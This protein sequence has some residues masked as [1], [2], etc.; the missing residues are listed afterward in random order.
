MVRTRR[1]RPELTDSWA[2]VDEDD[3]DN[4]SST[5]QS[6]SQIYDEAD[7]RREMA[8]EY[9]SRIFQ[10]ERKSSRLNGSTSNLDN[11]DNARRRSLRSSVEPPEL[12]MPAS[13][14]G[15][16]SSRSSAASAVLQNARAAKQRASTPHFRMNERSMTSDAGSM[17]KIPERTSAPRFRMSDR[18]MTSDAGRIHGGASRLKEE[19]V[20]DETYG[21]QR[22]DKGNDAVAAGVG[23][24]WQRVL[25]PLLSYTTSVV[26]L[27]VENAKPILGW[28]L[29][30][31]VLVAAFVFA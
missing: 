3:Y 23:M 17:R 7:E 31:Y 13:P 21:E 6:N 9:R 30:L 19:I 5:T 8:D 27:A 4:T 25:R 1:A 20:D 18:S 2:D 29:L 15:S 14:D 16:S 11:N 22:G 26:G 28:A 10:D 24:L 12:V